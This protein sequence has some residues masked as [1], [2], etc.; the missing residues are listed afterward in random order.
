MKKSI[1]PSF[2]VRMAAL[3]QARKELKAKADKEKALVDDMFKPIDPLERQVKAS[4]TMKP[5]EATTPTPDATQ[6]IEVKVSTAMDR[7]IQKLREQATR[8]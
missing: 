5:L 3:R 4:L 1:K 8:I 2:G 6:Q 7:A